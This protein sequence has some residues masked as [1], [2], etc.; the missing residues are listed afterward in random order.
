MKTYDAQSVAQFFIDISLN[1]SISINPLKLIKLVYIAHG[2]RLGLAGFP[3]INEPPE[4]WQ[5]GP[6]IPSLYRELKYLGNDSITCGLINFRK[7]ERYKWPDDDEVIKLL[8]EIWRIYKD[9]SARMLSTIAHQQGSPWETARTANNGRYRN[10]E[11]P[12]EVIKSY[13]AKKANLNENH[14]K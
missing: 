4:A 12:E 14:R 13:Y 3:L 7:L 5:Y 1:Q 11:I 6:I 2:W 9:K 10:P 8:V